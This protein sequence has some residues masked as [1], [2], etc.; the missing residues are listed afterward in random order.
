MQKFKMEDKN[1]TSEFLLFFSLSIS[2][3]L[4]FW[5]IIIN[6]LSGKHQKSLKYAKLLYKYHCKIY[7]KN[8]KMADFKNTRF[9]K[10]LNPIQINKQIQSNSSTKMIK[11]LSNCFHFH[12]N[13][14]KILNLLQSQAQIYITSTFSRI[15]LTTQQAKMNNKANFPCHEIWAKNVST[16]I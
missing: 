6:L 8:F 16:N 4:N 2:L 12:H 5:I 10:I 9:C 15:Y 14:H 1:F 11:S 3:V 7:F 13:T